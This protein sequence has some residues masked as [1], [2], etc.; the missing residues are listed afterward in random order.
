[1]TMFIDTLLVNCMNIDFFKDK[2]FV[3]GLSR[4]RKCFKDNF[5]L[6]DLSWNRKYFYKSRDIYIGGLRSCSTSSGD[7]RRTL[8]KI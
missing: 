2:L 8:R 1:M 4:N 7:V 3:W 6:W 5:F